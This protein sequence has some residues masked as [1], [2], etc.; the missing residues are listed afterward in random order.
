[1]TKIEGMKRT[2]GVLVP[3]GVLDQ[4]MVRSVLENRLIVNMRINVTRVADYTEN[5]VKMCINEV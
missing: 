3:K 2:L 5:M 4:C 1:M